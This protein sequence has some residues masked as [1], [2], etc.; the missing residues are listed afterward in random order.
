MRPS[1]RPLLAL[2]V[3]TLADPARASTGDAVRWIG[4]L[5][6]GLVHFPV[7]LV[8]AAGLAE[9]V[10]MRKRSESYAFAARFMLYVA[11]SCGVLAA[12]AG[13]A[14]A[15]GQSFEGRQALN[16]DYHRVLGIALPVLLFLTIGLAES[17]RRTGEKWQLTAYRILLLLCV[18]IVVV[19]AYLGGT[20]VFGVGHLLGG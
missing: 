2:A 11:V 7:A 5:H 12:A 3:L 9:A 20:L 13:F 16:L 6:P 4:G 19:T 8:I 17:A 14:A 1:V 18:V 15:A 10:A